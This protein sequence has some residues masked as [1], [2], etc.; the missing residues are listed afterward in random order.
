MP[1]YSF[2][3]IHLIGPDSDKTAQFYEKMFKAKIV[4]NRELDFN[5]TRILLGQ[6]PPAEPATTSS[7]TPGYGLEHFGIRTDNI[8]AAV[9]DLKAK[10]ARFRDEIREVRPGIKIAFLW[11]PENVLIEL[12]ERKG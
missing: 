1:N 12:L 2:D 10:G 7:S 11:G 9:A 3:H 5:G 8:E 6:R 4:N